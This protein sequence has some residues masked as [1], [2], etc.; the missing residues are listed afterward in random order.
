MLHLTLGKDF[1]LYEKVKLNPM[2]SERNV[3]NSP[4]FSIPP[5]NISAPTTVARIAG[6]Q[7]DLLAGSARNVQAGAVISW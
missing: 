2:L 3:L 6:T 4:N 7:G 1:P 5:A